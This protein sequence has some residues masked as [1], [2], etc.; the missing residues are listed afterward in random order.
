MVGMD[1]RQSSNGGATTLDFVRIN[2][3]KKIRLVL[4][5]S[6]KRVRHQGRDYLVVP[7]TMLVPGVLNGSKGPL[8]YPPEEVSRN[9]DA[10]NGM[11]LT[12]DHPVDNESGGNVSAR[13]PGV[14]EKYGIGHVYR[15]RID[16]NN[17]GKLKGEAWFDEKRVIE[18]DQILLQNNRPTILNRLLRGLP[19]ELSTGLF[20][21]NTPVR[22]GIAPNG[23]KYVAVARDYKPDH[24]AILPDSTG[25][26]SLKDGCGVHIAN[27][28]G[29]KK[30][31]KGKPS[32]KLDM[33]PSKACKILK[34]GSVHG[35]PLTEK[36]RGM[37]GAKCGEKGKKPT[38]N[39]A[40][41]AMFWRRMLRNLVKFLPTNK[42][43]N[44]GN[45]GIGSGG[46][47]KG[48]HCASGGGSHEHKSSSHGA[49]SG[50]TASLKED[51]S[52]GRLRASNASNKAF[53]ASHTA[54]E[55]H[56]DERAEKLSTTARKLAKRAMA[57]VG[58]AG[59]TADHH[60]A[61]SKAHTKAAQRHDE[62]DTA[63][64][65]GGAVYHGIAFHAHRDA[66]AAHEETA[67]S[68]RRLLMVKNARKME[69]RR[70]KAKKFGPIPVRNSGGNCGIGEGGFQKGNTCASGGGGSHSSSPGKSAAHELAQHFA[71]DQL[72]DPGNFRNKWRDM[73][74]ADRKEVHAELKKRGLLTPIDA[75]KK[76]PEKM[77]ATE[78]IGSV[79]TAYKKAKLD[80]ESIPTNRHEPFTSSATYKK[81]IGESVTG[82]SS[83]S[84][85][86]GGSAMTGKQKMIR[87]LTNN[88]DCW[89][90][91]ESVLNGMDENRLKT[92]IR[93]FK[94]NQQNEAIANAVRESLDESGEMDLEELTTV[95]AN[96]LKGDH[97]EGTIKRKKKKSATCTEP[98]EDD[99]DM[100]TNRTD[101]ESLE[102][103][104]ER[105]DVP[106]FVKRLVKNQLK[107]EQQKI[108]QVVNRLKK[109]AKV[110]ANKQ[111][112]TLI[113]NKLKK[114]ED[115]PLSLESLEELLIATNEEQ[116]GN[117]NR[118]PTG[119]IK[120]VDDDDTD[121]DSDDDDDEGVTN[122]LTNYGGGGGINNRRSKQTE[123]GDE[124]VENGEADI[125]A[126]ITPEIDYSE[127]VGNM[128]K[129]D[130][131]KRNIGRG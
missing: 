75:R 103:F 7:V 91:G 49:T 62:L 122:R 92:L 5:T 32:K 30:K 4:N 54:L 48:N 26:C 6:A 56:P 19:I 83:F 57:G 114:H 118:R 66:A 23:R 88:C 67:R 58:Y 71:T 11:P 109:V 105:D 124:Y 21:R 70:M 96:A 15:V 131:R 87:Y 53:F 46:F 113:V 61:A 73:E 27:S 2:R 51:V 1:T 38:T 35:H 59:G 115:T 68:M 9:V 36:Q 97:T 126:M 76:S 60:E 41:R 117:G 93:S 14:L 16:R 77:T 28:T 112:K 47:Q 40:G 12:L 13:D 33:S 45:C 106:K 121:D 84:P 125:E 78:V 55:K 79:Q 127:L 37:F 86:K 34:D 110:T 8:Y 98:D 65:G 20:T 74:S 102:E 39:Y 43:N 107:Q 123:D 129:V 89:K 63:M 31:G 104:L 101:D 44:S 52:N 17:G 18:F 120:K 29:R 42:V 3:T 72:H 116:M 119:N 22:N 64:S 81:M 80:H 130:E 108:E 128:D 99:K 111:K 94:Q 90:G 24:L 10:W 50:V 69:R 100:A 25:A 85:E 82:N 95:T